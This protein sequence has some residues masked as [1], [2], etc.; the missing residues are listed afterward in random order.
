MTVMLPRAMT[1]GGPTQTHMSPRRAAGI[2]P[3]S[4]V[5][6]PR[7]MGPPTWGTTP[8]TIGQTCISAILAAGADMGSTRLAPAPRAAI[9]DVQPLFQELSEFLGSSFRLPT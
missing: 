9:G 4:T 3:M 1:S 8:V 2:L 5:K 6:Q 7:V